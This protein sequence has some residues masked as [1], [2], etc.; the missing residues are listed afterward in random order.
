LLV[1]IRIFTSLLIA[2][3]LITLSPVP[4]KA[5]VPLENGIT[6]LAQ[7][8]VQNSQA[9]SLASIAIVPFVNSDGSYSE[10]SNFVV[11]ELVLKLFTIPG[12]SM[13]IVERQ[14]L[15]AMLAEMSL[16]WADI[17]SASSTQKLGK[18]HGVQGLVI[19][20][21]TDMTDS[22]RI[23]ARL[24]ETETGGVF[25][26]AAINVSKSP[27]VQALLGRRIAMPG[28]AVAGAGGGT[29]A[30]AVGTA[31]SLGASASSYANDF[32]RASVSKVSKSERGDHVHISLVLEN[33]TQE[34]IALLTWAADNSASLTDDAGVSPRWVKN[35]GIG[36]CPND[37]SSPGFKTRCRSRAAYTPIPPQ[38]RTVISLSFRGKEIK[39]AQ[40]D[41]S[42][43]FLAFTKPDQA[44]PSNFTLGITGIPLAGAK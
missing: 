14:Q 26:A 3:L 4:A 9:K 17:V 35:G 1:S 11:D 28:Y 25:S 20:S 29:A 10:L 43:R 32:L 6:E 23:T 18:V 38:G 37:L 21:I 42:A 24:I 39:G 19:G 30:P 31:P 27:T 40:A 44:E 5:Q 16:G 36:D 34:E 22:L 7:Q 8:I 2:A 33:A 12:N 41:L 13:K 15:G